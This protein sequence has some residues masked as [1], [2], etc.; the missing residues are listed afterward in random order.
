[1]WDMFAMENFKVVNVNGLE[2]LCVWAGKKTES[3]WLVIK[4]L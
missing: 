4:I 1:M 3:G 2:V